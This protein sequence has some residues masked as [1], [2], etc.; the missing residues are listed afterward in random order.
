MTSSKRSTATATATAILAILATSSVPSSRTQA[1]QPSSLATSPTRNNN[2]IISAGNNARGIK[3]ILKMVEGN[4]EELSEVEKLRAAAAKA[5]EEYERLSKEMGKEIATSSSASTATLTPPK[6]LTTAELQTLAKSIDFESGDAASQSTALDS[7]VSSGRFSLWK[8]AVRRSPSSGGSN[9]M[10]SL[11]QPFPVSLPNLESRTNGQITPESLNIG[12]QSDVKFEDFR[13]LTVAVVLI[14]SLLAV[15]SLAFLPPNL[16]AGLSYLLAL[17]PIGFIGVGSTAP[18]LIAGAIQMGR[19][20]K[21]E[22]EV[23]RERICRHEAGH[24]LCGYLCGLPVKGYEV[25]ADTGVAC[26]EFHTD[27]NANSKG[28]LSNDEIAALAVVA[29]SGS[30]AEI[31]A[32]GKATGGENDLLELQ[33]CFRRSEEF[34]GAAKQ[35]DLTRWGALTSYNLIRNNL[36]RYEGLVEAFKEKRSLAECVAI[37]E[38][39]SS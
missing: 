24:F 25:N 4:G 31:M 38:G 6:S 11:L 35:Q 8:S 37:I 17:I 30:V 3:P 7:L 33:N 12:G 9:N 28:E 21:E 36:G 19:G 13:D 26:V 10:M 2:I 5:R 22:G 14:S 16:G 27:G 32:Y 23:L 29:M 20:G 15:L 18:G 1:F 34:I 39:S